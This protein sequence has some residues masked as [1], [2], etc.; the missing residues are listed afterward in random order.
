[1]NTIVY[2]VCVGHKVSVTCTGFSYDGKHV[3]TADMARVWKVTNGQC[4]WK[5]E[6]MDF[7]YIV[8]GCIFNVL[9]SSGFLE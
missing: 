3:A 1:V 6:C 8:F 5:Y 9:F 4:I 7:E 2:T